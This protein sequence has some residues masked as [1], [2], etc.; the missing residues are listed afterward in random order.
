V[1]YDDNGVSDGDSIDLGAVLE[2][3]GELVDSL[4]K[5]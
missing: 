3:H 4:E 1:F 5:E 2:I